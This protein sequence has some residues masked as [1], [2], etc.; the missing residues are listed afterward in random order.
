[1]NTET[2]FIANAEIEKNYTGEQR[3]SVLT[4]EFPTIEEAFKWIDKVRK[5]LDINGTC[6][7]TY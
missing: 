2:S 7:P 4:K 6:F 5:R 1:M 3:L